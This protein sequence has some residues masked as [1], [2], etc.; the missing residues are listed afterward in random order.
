MEYIV[1]IATDFGE[2]Q[3]CFETCEILKNEEEALKK[4][5][6]ELQ[7][8]KIINVS[9]LTKERIIFEV[10]EGLFL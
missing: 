5:L 3:V 6:D 10:T 4:A 9:E 2:L 1:Y 8:S 7:R